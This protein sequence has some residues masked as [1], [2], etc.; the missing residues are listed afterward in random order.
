MKLLMNERF[1]EFVLS[2]LLYVLKKIITNPGEY[3]LQT[4]HGKAAVVLHNKIIIPRKSL[5]LI[6]KHF[7]TLFL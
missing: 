2:S 1:E 3:C 7:R 5:I 6:R 4:R